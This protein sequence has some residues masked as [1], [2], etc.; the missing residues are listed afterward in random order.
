[1]DASLHLYRKNELMD[2]LFFFSSFFQT[3]V[4]F[5]GSLITFDGIQHDETFDI[6]SKIAVLALRVIGFP[7]TDLKLTMIRFL[8]GEQSEFSSTS[9]K[10]LLINQ[11]KQRR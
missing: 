11:T 6:Q 10:G 4:T 2:L 5:T 8:S 1:M 7:L 3:D 9:G